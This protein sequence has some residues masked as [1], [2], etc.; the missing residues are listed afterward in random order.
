[1]PFGSRLQSP[2]LMFIVRAEFR[3]DLEFGASLERVRALLGDPQTFARLMPGVESILED[4]KVARWIVRA[5]VPLV[6]AMRGTFVLTQTDDS[7]RRV[8]WEPDSLEEKNLLR[9]A[10]SFEERGQERE[11]TLV[12]IALRVELRR[13]HAAAL[14]PMAGFIGESRIRAGTETR[15]AKMMKI[16]LERARSELKSKSDGGG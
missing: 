16:F 7:A 2:R 5:D 13:R 6:G 8:E 1:M 12:R 4:G 14:H 15:V 9:Y 3:E 11:I 10:I